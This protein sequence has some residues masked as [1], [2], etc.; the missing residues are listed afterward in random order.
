MEATD[1]D[2]VILDINELNF[3]DTERVEK[4]VTQLTEACEG[5][6][7]FLLKVGDHHDFGNLCIQMIEAAKQVF[8]LPKE[9]KEPLVNDGTSQQYHKGLNYD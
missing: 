9:E 2:L 1:C 7:F 8:A 5:P 6:G 3:E 4:L